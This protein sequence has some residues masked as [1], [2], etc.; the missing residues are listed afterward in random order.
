MNYE[1]QLEH[2]TKQYEELIETSNIAELQRMVEEL[3]ITISE[4][5]HKFTELCD[6]VNE[7]SDGISYSENRELCRKFDTLSDKIR[8]ARN[9]SGCGIYVYSHAADGIIP[10]AESYC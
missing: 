5:M 1:E 10:W 3:K 6:S 8:S 9:D 2:F 7:V 4:E